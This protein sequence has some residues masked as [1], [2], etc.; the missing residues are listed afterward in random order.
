MTRFENYVLFCF[1]LAIAKWY[2]I[3]E[4]GVILYYKSVAKEI[5]KPPNFGC[6]TLEGI[7][8]CQFC[9]ICVQTTTIFGVSWDQN[10]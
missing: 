10:G 4:R 6:L 1:F 3:I 5:L 8:V 2:K 9:A 7:K